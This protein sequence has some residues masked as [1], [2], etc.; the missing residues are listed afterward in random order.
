MSGWLPPS[1]LLSIPTSS[2]DGSPLGELHP[3]SANACAVHALFIV[4]VIESKLDRRFINSMVQ[5]FRWRRVRV[6]AHAH[7]QTRS[8]RS[9]RPCLDRSQVQKPCVARRWALTRRCSRERMPIV[10]CKHAFQR[11]EYDRTP[12]ACATGSLTM[13]YHV[14]SLSPSEFG[15]ALWITQ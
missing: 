1:S 8:T 5:F 15:V 11:Y 12:V 2:L 3:S 10:L 4:T 14:T 9:F 6:S 13:L 7:H